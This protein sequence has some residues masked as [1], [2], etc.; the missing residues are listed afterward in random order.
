MRAAVLHN[1]PGDLS[2]EAVVVNR[3]EPTE[4][5]VRTRAAGLCHSD[6]HHLQGHMPGQHL[7]RVLGHESAGVVEAVGSSVTDVAVGD[8]VVTCPS[9]FC[10]SCDWCLAGHPSLCDRVGTERSRSAEPR[11]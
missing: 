1:S 8:H 9:V 11:L 7:P 10:G 3:L 5:L 4:V 6:L 2:V